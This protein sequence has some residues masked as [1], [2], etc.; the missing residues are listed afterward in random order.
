MNNQEKTVGSQE[1]IQYPWCSHVMA[2]LIGTSARNQSMQDK[3]WYEQH[4]A[5]T[6][7]LAAVQSLRWINS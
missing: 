4:A 1:N 6:A 2:A 7:T 3:Q 5:K